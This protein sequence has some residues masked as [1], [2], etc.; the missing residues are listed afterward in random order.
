[1]QKLSA[2][3]YD[4]VLANIVADVIIPLAPVVPHFV[5]PDGLFIC[6]GILDQRL[7]EVET[8]IRSAG[9][10]IASVRKIDDWCQITALP[11]QGG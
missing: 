10:E 2:E 4:I 9:L 6:S 11:R 3:K 8:A 1:M 5:K 7:S